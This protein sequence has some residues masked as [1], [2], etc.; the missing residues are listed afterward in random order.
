MFDIAYSFETPLL[1][2]VKIFVVVVQL[3]TY[4][5]LIVG[6]WDLYQSILL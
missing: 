5:V 4:S 2:S 1:E 6:G 3:Q